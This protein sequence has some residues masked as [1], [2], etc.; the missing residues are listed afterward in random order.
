MFNELLSYT[1]IVR[2]DGPGRFITTVDVAKSPTEVG[3][4]RLRLFTLDGNRLVV[5][6][7]EAA[8]PFS[9]GRVAFFDNVFF[10]EHPTT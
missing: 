2:S 5:R 6:V 10:R 9:Q 7:P 3:E 1:G 8:S 4:E